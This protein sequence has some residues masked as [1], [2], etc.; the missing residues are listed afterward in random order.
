MSVTTDAENLAERSLG[1][2]N[3]AAG[4]IAED[5]KSET[6]TR[7]RGAKRAVDDAY[8]QTRDT[9]LGA[10]GE[11]EGFLRDKALMA[12]GIVAGAG[13]LLGFALR[14]AGKSRRRQADAASRNAPEPGA[15]PH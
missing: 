10:M 7:L 5:M 9:A 13:L 8:G 1:R 4:A 6:K 12:V 15:K 2:L 3:D 11:A 14:G